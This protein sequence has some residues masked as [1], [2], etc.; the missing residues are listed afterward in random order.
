MHSAATPATAAAAVPAHKPAAAGGV[1]LD[2]LSSRAPGWDARRMGP[3]HGGQSG[4]AVVS[5]VV[6]VAAAVAVTAAGGLLYARQRRVW[7]QRQWQKLSG[8]E[9]AE[10]GPALLAGYPGSPAAP[11]AEG[12]PQRQPSPPAAAQQ[13]KVAAAPSPAPAA[14][15]AIKARLAASVAV[16]QP[17]AAAARA[18][19][20]LRDELESWDGAIDLMPLEALPAALAQAAQQ[21]QQQLLQQEAGE[22]G[23][24]AAHQQ[25]AAA[26]GFPGDAG[27][28]AAA[29]ALPAA[30][31]GRVEEITPIEGQLQPMQQQQWHSLAPP[32]QLQ[33]HSQAA[34]GTAQQVSSYPGS[35]WSPAGP[36][37]GHLSSGVTSS[38]GMHSSGMPSSRGMHSS[39]GV[40]SARST[41]SMQSCSSMG[42]C[43]G[44]WN[45][46]NTLL[47]LSPGELTV[48]CGRAVVTLWSCCC[49]AVVAVLLSSS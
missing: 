13:Q 11:S 8:C 40:H 25:G 48:R 16:E 41:R 26:A 39:R 38:R 5:A 10:E 42:A 47:L 30:A 12:S 43:D 6:A 29:A 14:I 17:T 27:S 15:A 33:Q 2:A 49:C 7:Q 3:A 37:S 1:R 46:Q 20:L 35:H 19:A 22:G 28:V 32:P 4:A 18:A 24:W 44:Q 9:A 21:Q 36:A 45:L 34:C 23:A 31:A